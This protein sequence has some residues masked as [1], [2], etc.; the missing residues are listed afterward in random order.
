MGKPLHHAL[1]EYSLCHSE[2]FIRS[3]LHLN[4]PS[5]SKTLI[6][7][8]CL[9][10]SDADIP[11]ISN[12]FLTADRAEP[13]QTEKKVSFLGCPSRCPDMCSNHV[14]GAELSDVL[15]GSEKP[16]AKSFWFHG[17]VIQSTTFHTNTDVLG[18]SRVTTTTLRTIIEPRMEPLQLL[19]P[20]EQPFLKLI[21]TSE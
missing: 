7:E 12:C 4:Q 13:P 17:D 9:L 15:A 16:S 20:N 19:Q 21:P 3:A 5:G 2:N 10:W 14:R 6:K 11:S 1:G 18:I 8:Q